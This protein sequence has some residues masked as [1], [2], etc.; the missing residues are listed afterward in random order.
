MIVL[1]FRAEQ[2]EYKWSPLTLFRQSKGE[3]RPTFICP[4]SRT[5]GFPS[6]RVCI[7]IVYI[8]TNDTL[9]TEESETVPSAKTITSKDLL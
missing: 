1:C 5:V 9:S 8:H 2:Q 7:H 4:S 3:T 6:H